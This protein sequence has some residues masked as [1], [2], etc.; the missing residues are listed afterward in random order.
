[1]RHLHLSTDLRTFF[2]MKW[3]WD[4]ASKAIEKDVRVLQAAILDVAR[5][6]E[7]LP[8][9]DEPGPDL[10][11]I[12]ETLARH[13]GLLDGYEAR[14]KDLMLAISEGIEKT[15]RA[16][17]RVKATISRA[18]KEFA[19]N[20]LL[21]P[22][23]EAE[24]EQLRLVDG[25]GGGEGELPPVQLDLEEGIA[26]EEEEARARQLAANYRLRGLA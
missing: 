25:A 23:L 11:P 12:R 8:D 4:K 20:G 15:S 19:R 21:D 18:R 9:A 26:L 16:E 6:V 3:G 1:M 10:G 5:E 7:A 2:G 22:G 17:N 14:L 13:E 24:A